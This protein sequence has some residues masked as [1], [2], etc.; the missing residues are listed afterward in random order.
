MEHLPNLDDYECKWYDFNGVKFPYWDQLPLKIGVK[1]S[2]GIDSATIM[3]ILAYLKKQNLLHP[4]STL[5]SFT[6]QNWNRPYQVEFVNK[7]L[8]L[9]KE[10]LDVTVKLEHWVEGDPYGTQDMIDL[11]EAQ[12]QVMKYAYETFKIDMNYTGRS[13]FLPIDFIDGTMFENE[14]SNGCHGPPMPYK[15]MLNLHHPDNHR[16]NFDTDMQSRAWEDTPEEKV[17]NGNTVHP[18]INLNKSH[19]KICSDYLGVTDELIANT[20]SCEYFE[21]PEEQYLDYEKHCGD[22]YWCVERLV[23]YGKTDA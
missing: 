11:E 19:V 13:K 14:I 17:C 1:M 10:K 5:H 23:T 3:Y 12:E 22:C 2:G 8:Q 16:Y 7:A 20:R 15:T 9:I 4:Q 6:A 18:W 21:A